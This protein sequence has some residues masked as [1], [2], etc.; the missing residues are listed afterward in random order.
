MLK[1]I[2]DAYGEALSAYNELFPLYHS[3][4]VDRGEI[5]PEGLNIDLGEKD[6]INAF[7]K[8]ATEMAFKLKEA[9]DKSG[10]AVTWH[11]GESLEGLN[12]SLKKRVLKGLEFGI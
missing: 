3:G 10:N 11:R 12:Q 6:N 9:A 2:R 8:K 5:L 1:E 4:R 7:R